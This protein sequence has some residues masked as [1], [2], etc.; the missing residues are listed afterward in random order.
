[1]RSWI[2][3]ACELSGAD[4]RACFRW[5]LAPLLAILLPALLLFSRPLPLEAQSRQERGKQL[6]EECL[7]AVGGTAFLAVNN[8]VQTGRAYSFYRQN[9][10]GLAVIT[11]YT[12][13]EPMRSSEDPDWLPVSRR[14]V[15]TKKGDYYALFQN[16][17]GWEVTFRGARPFP[18][19][20]LRRYRDSTRRN[21]FYILRYR[22]QE[23][24][25]YY[26]YKGTEIID[27][28]PTDAVEITDSQN[29]SVT[30]YLRMP[31][32]LPVQQV[33]TRRDPKT[34][35]PHEEKS[36]FSKYRREGGVLLPWN[37]RS[38]RNGEKIFELFGRT[39]ALNQDLKDDF[40][41]LKEI[42]ILPPLP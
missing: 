4:S 13:Y 34:R 38:E 21:I 22:L 36:I 16:G 41:S 12:K 10:R 37:I 42:Q 29:D 17:K 23:P 40:F 3:T 1:M 31:D 6:L 30:I 19:D 32:H 33:Y 14:E 39:A 15:Y 18:G 27:N 35:I 25:M 7:R 9:L 28:V 11:V 26:Y 2:P 24:G 5:Q 20:Y 8:V